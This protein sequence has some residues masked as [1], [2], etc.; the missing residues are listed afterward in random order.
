MGKTTATGQGG[1]GAAFWPE[2][3]GGGL[4]PL[5]GLFGEESFLVDQAVEAFLASP[6]FAQNP[7][8]NIERFQAD[9]VSPARVLEAA[10]GLPFLGKKRLVVLAGSNAYK[11]AD[12]NRFLDYLADPAPTTC[13]LF[14]GQKLDIRTKFA[15][16][17]KKQGKVQVFN[18]MYPD[19]L[20]AWLSARAATRGKRLE[21]SAANRLA[22]LSGLGLA[23][24]DMEVEKLA[25]FAAGEPVITQ[26]HVDQVVGK[27]RLYSI[28]DFTDAIAV[29]SLNRALSAWDQL[30]S[31][32][33]PAVRALAMVTRLMRQL[34]EVRGI[35]DQG[36]NEA[37]VRSALRV[38]PGALNTLMQRARRE[39]SANLGG[40]LAR[41]LE[42]DVALKSSPG[43]D[44]VIME[45]LVMDLCRAGGSRQAS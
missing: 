34:L 15:K 21:P 4:G 14:T 41:L 44:R 40:Y 30:H 17:L 5:Y 42:A 10:A 3:A 23:S 8:L 12:L 27:G 29:G 32:G 24:L 45:R 11:A 37:Q 9:E 33:E 39:S 1:D 19:K 36:G 18:K 35:L 25:L 13:L 7:S 22:E 20:P 38:P 31:L 6:D 28:F 26:E 43:S 2:T 16:A